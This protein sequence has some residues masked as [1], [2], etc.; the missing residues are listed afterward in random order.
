MTETTRLPVVKELIAQVMEEV[1][2]CPQT[3]KEFPAACPLADEVE[4]C[5]GA[6]ETW[7]E[8]TAMTFQMRWLLGMNP[9]NL[10]EA[11]VTKSVSA[12]TLKAA[13]AQPGVS[14]GR[15][16]MLKW[17]YEGQAAVEEMEQMQ[18]PGQMPP[19]L[20]AVDRTTK[21][22]EQSI[23]IMQAFLDELMT[24]LKTHWLRSALMIG[25]LEELAD[26][27]PEYLMMLMENPQNPKQL[28]MAPFLVLVGLLEAL[29]DSQQMTIRHRLIQQ[30]QPNLRKV[31]VQER[32]RLQTQMETEAAHLL[33]ETIGSTLQSSNPL[34]NLKDLN[35]CAATLHLRSVLPLNA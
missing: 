2:N 17:L 13:M 27:R 26:R 29:L 24:H 28:A 9:G 25:A 34:V 6:N 22:S 30:Q 4:G 5:L 35:P 11:S 10:L 15:K 20:D 3:P 21:A 8:E 18:N 12:E 1:K 32:I 16:H 23:E 14:G 33:G 19:E 31:P 7:L